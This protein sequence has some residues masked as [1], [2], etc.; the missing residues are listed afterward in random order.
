MSWAGL[1][2]GAHMAYIHRL[3]SGLW[4]A[5][6]ARKGTRRTSTH[7]TKSAAEQWATQAEAEILAG[8][9]GEFPRKTV[10]DALTRYAEEVSP[11][12]RTGDKEALRLAAFAREKWT[13]K[14]VSYTHLTLPT[15]R[16]V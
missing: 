2:H 15:K 9:R 5:E 4:R 12:K 1:T 16:I 7:Q 6:V 13:A 10:R 3:P 8:V 11:T 14:S